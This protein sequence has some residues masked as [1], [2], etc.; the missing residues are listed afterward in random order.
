MNILIYGHRGWIGSQFVTLLREIN[1]SETEVK[2]HHRI[3]L[4]TARVD[5]DEDLIREID[6]IRPTH[7]ISFIGRTHG[8]IG[9]R[10][11]PT[12]D[13]LEQPDRLVENV[14]DNLYAPVLLALLSRRY[15]Y[16]FT[17]LGTGCI[18]SY[19][20]LH[21]CPN[22]DDVD[23]GGL[24]RDDTKNL[25]GF[26][27]SDTP[28]FTGSG[29][30]TVKGF[31][32]RLA[33]YLPML[34]LRIRMPITGKSNPRNF[35]TKICKYEKICSIP[36]SMSV[37]PTLLPL[38]VDMMNKGLQGS[39]NLTNPGVI[40]HNRILTLYREHVDPNHTWNNFTIQQQDEVLDAKRS[41]N[42]LDTTRLES[43]YPN[44]PD[45]EQAVTEMLK[46]FQTS[47]D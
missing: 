1:Q 21:P 36:N 45:I 8:K 41:N 18:F 10:V 26:L 24:L 23:Q 7:V 39:I 38:V 17:Y 47:E 32:D 29:Y 14:R 25:Q 28:N 42:Y 19:D 43:L 27:E 22:V 33:H 13:Y 4:G 11:Y 40:T 9:D 16:H 30:S 46:S 44:V 5:H 34:N 15:N 6:R 35:I 12:I 37:L 3:N 20:S 31:T 2:N